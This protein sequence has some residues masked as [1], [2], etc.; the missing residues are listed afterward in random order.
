MTSNT[1]QAKS[2][3]AT[4]SRRRRSGVE[5]VDVLI[6]LIP[7]LQFVRITLIG[8]LNGSDLMMLAVFLYL[9]FDR[10]IRIPTPVARW[11]LVL[12]L[13]WLASL[14]VTDIVRHSA[15]SDYARGWSNIGMTL[16]NL[17]VFWT[18]LYGRPRRLVLFGWGLAIGG[19]LLFYVNPTEILEGASETVAWKFVFAYSVSL[20]VFLIA[21]GKERRSHWPITLALI[22][23][24][25]NMVQ[26]S[27]NTGGECLAAALYLSV[28]RIMRR[29]GPGNSKLRARTAIALAVSI[30][31]GVVG[32]MWAYGRAAKA[33]ILGEDAQRKYEQ[34][35]SGKYGVLLGGRIELLATIPAIYDSPI[36]GHGSWAK[37]PIYIIQMHRALLLLGYRIAAKSITPDDMRSGYIPE[38]SYFFGA[39]VDAG[40]LGAVFWVWI[41]VSTARVLMRAY[42]ADAE[43]LPVGSFLAFLL[44]WN[45]LF[46]PWGTDARFTFPYSFVLLMTLMDTASGT[47][48]Q[49]PASRAKNRI[50]TKLAP[51][52]QH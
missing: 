10:K 21:S 51:R 32:V 40:I 46:S 1:L 22:M 29:K 14:C 49:I 7:C 33:G 34:E 16:V 48:E 44:L 13:L 5:G 45:V 30:L 20:G 28:I 17:T 36:L 6:I 37:D 38:H 19:V 25:F 15:F 35:S 52:L 9:V 27:R 2:P 43:L 23:G 42:P 41:L 4:P 47:A 31:V 50:K 39:W 18:L 24:A 3:G 8:V 26:G 12:G 11:T